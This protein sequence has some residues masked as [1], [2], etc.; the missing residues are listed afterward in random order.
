MRILF[1]AQTKDI[2]GMAEMEMKISGTIRVE[3]VWE[4]LAAIQ[5]RLAAFRKTTRL[6][7]NG[8]YV[9][10]QTKFSD[11]DEV[12]LIPPVSGG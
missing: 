3:E 12:A 5:P 6:A 11:G 4:K 1:F 7:R 2:A 9:N 10:A 8:E